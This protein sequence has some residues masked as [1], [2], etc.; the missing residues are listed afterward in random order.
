M[1]ARDLYRINVTKLSEGTMKISDIQG[2]CAMK[3]EELLK[4]LA[5]T[6][7]NTLEVWGG[8]I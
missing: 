8:G 5:E 4:L 6:H 2:I 3:K 1:E 7:G